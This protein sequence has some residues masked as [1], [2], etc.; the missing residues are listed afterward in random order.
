MSD[1]TVH[2]HDVEL[3][4]VFV[5]RNVLI[6]VKGHREDQVAVGVDVSPSDDG[7]VDQCLIVRLND[8]VEHAAHAQIQSVVGINCT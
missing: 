5:K 1:A 7:A 2:R 6:D 8:D 4:G 3:D